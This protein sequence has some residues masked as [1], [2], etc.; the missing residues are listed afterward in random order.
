MSGFADWIALVASTSKGIGA[1][2]AQ[3]LA[4]EGTMAVF[5]YA[6]SKAVAIR[7]DVTK[8]DGV[9][10]LAQEIRQKFGRLDVLVNDARLHDMALCDRQSVSESNRHF[11]TNVLELPLVTREA[12]GLFPATGASIVAINSV[13][14]T[15]APPGSVIHVA[16]KGA[17]APITKVLA[18]VLAPRKIRINSVNP[19]MA[20]TEGTQSADFA[21]GEFEAQALAMM[22]LGR[23]R[24]P[25]Y[26]A[27]AFALLASDEASSIIGETLIVSG[28]MGM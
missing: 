25:D 7:A 3:R 27:P 13:I 19:G 9:V 11:D 18:K 26:I 24:A 21:G 23:I 6:S 10:W 16:T 22:P 28:G 1:G 5:T 8:E 12:A 15:L 2:I 4:T 14:S 17:V 20:E